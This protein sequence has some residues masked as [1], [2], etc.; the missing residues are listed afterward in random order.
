MRFDIDKQTIN[1]LELF[2]KIKGEKSVISLFNFT[3]SFGGKKRLESIFYNPLSDIDSVERRI[4]IV[5]CFQELDSDFT[6][7]KECLDFIE[8]YL[9]QQNVPNR[10]SISNSFFKTLSYICNYCIFETR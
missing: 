6:I 5:R 1:D 8:Y 9:I 2:E 4:D 10:F 3:K 7:D